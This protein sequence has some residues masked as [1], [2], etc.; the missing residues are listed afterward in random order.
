MITRS[1]RTSERSRSNSISNSIFRSVSSKTPEKE[2][3][4]GYPVIIN[5][6]QN[7][8]IKKIYDNPRRYK[9]RC[10]KR[11]SRSKYTSKYKVLG[12][13]TKINVHSYSRNN[14]YRKKVPRKF[15]LKFLNKNKYKSI[16]FFPDEK[17]LKIDCNLWET[18]DSTDPILLSSSS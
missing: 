13:F 1:N 9:N 16:D 5:P 11:L 7:I 6:K 3:V 4:K 17:I 18:S 8:T 15:S 10:F 14:K 2:I 12:Y